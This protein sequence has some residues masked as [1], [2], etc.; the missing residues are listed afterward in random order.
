MA[1]LNVALFG[2]SFNPIHQGHLLIA[3]TL[4]EKPEVDEVW[5]VL[6]KQAPLKENVSVAFEHRLAM[7][8]LAIQNISGL[9]VC[10][11]ENELPTPSYTID[12]LNALEKKYDHHFYW[13]IGSD[14]A[15]QIEQWKEYQ[16]LLV[17]M[18][19]YV[20]LRD[21]D[22]SDDS[23]FRYIQSLSDTSSTDIRDGKSNDAPV[24][25]LQ[26]MIMNHLYDHSIVQSHMSKYRY[27]HTVSV[28]NTALK[29]ADNLDIDKD[30]VVVASM[31]HD[32]A[33]EWNQEMA[34]YWLNQEDIT[35]DS[36]KNYEVHA[37]AAMA[38]LKHFYHIENKE[39]LDAIAHHVTG[40]SEELLAKIL[41]VADKTEP[42]RNYDTKH[43]TKLA[44][45]DLDK[46]FCKIKQD[47]Q[48]YNQSKG[49][50][51]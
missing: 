26:Y 38:Y 48:V 36:C 44:L 11:I 51:L 14:Q 30:D 6:A 28:C 22:T 10:T 5:F 20:I 41:Y 29:I 50:M 24:S 33:K 17:K 4:L 13:V 3:Q 31:Y 43:Y 35:I 9:K 7:I 19:F 25:V 12:T 18:P 21:Q 16:Q 47:N 46:A 32:I 42:T 8:N 39:I 34:S 23:R 2:G 27:N 49:G 37:Y 15:K 1:H 40:T 45:T